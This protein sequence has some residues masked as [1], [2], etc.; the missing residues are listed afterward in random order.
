[1]MRGDG[2][3]SDHAARARFAMENRLR[4]DLRDLGLKAVDTAPRLPD[5]FA[6]QG[7]SVA[8]LVGAS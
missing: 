4:L 5:P 2:D 8:D 3:L 6:R 1:M 7:R